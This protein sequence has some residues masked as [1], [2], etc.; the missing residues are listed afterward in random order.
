MRNVLNS[1]YV[2]TA[3][4]LLAV[5]LNGYTQDL[6]GSALEDDTTSSSEE[7]GDCQSYMPPEHRDDPDRLALR[8]VACFEQQEYLQA[9]I[10]YREAYAISKS[11][12]LRGAI[13]RALQE[14]GHPQFA[15]EYF[16]EYLE[17]QSPDTPGYQ[18]IEQRMKV[19]EQRLESEAVSVELNTVPAGAQAY[20]VLDDEYW[21]PVGTTPVTTRLLPGSYRAIYQRE[22]YVT[23]EELIEVDASSSPRKPA[24]LIVQEDALYASQDRLRSW[25]FYTML[26]SAP[27][28][29]GGGAFFVLAAQRSNEADDYQRDP[30]FDPGRRDELRDSSQTFSTLGVV[31]TSIGVGALLTGLVLYLIGNT[32]GEET[33]AATVFSSP[34]EVGFR[35]TW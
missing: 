17:A 7:S 24:E 9:L 14:L 16:A 15:R 27:F 2:A 21:E 5:P 32:Q 1:I 4:L 29:V 28:L 26:G 30:A 18:K 10:F 25:G 11:T 3:C 22:G 20:L 35:V 23:Q 31:S 13:G 12:A 8:G 33:D 19:V 34:S 6:P